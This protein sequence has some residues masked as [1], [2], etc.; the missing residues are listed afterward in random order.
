MGNVAEAVD[1]LGRA[2]AIVRFDAA[3]LRDRARLLIANGKEREAI[4]D[5]SILIGAGK[6][7]SDD[8]RRS[9]D[10]HADLKLWRDAINDYTEVLHREPDDLVTLLRR[11]KCYLDQ[12]DLSAAQADCDRVLQAMPDDPAA[13]RLKARLE[14]MQAN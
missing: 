7:S 13:L 5:Y 1:S 10:C 3:I 4:R 9:G 14:R 12:G 2:L 6:A 11:A 8:W